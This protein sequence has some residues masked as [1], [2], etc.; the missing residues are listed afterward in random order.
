M[1]EKAALFRKG[2]AFYNKNFVDKDTKNLYY[3][4][5]SPRTQK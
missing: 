2:G 3:G 1:D 5:M 4:H